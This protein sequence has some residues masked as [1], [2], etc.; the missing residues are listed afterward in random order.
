MQAQAS[1]LAYCLS[2]SALERVD[3]GHVRIDAHVRRHTFGILRNPGSRPD[4]H[5]VFSDSVV[6]ERVLT[7][8]PPPRL[9]QLS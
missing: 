8:A 6:H 4:Q 5:R 2:K 9:R 7:V 3:Q 1:R